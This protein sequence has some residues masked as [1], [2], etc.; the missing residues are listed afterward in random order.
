MVQPEQQPLEHGLDLDTV[1]LLILDTVILERVAKIFFLNGILKNGI[2]K[3]GVKMGFKK[4]D[5]K[6]RKY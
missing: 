2:L 4:M 1:K 5:I 3:K 6:K